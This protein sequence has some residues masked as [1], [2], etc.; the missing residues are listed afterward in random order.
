MA[1]N[2]WW[3]IGVHREDENEDEDEDDKEGVEYH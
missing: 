2:E 3:I 1:Q